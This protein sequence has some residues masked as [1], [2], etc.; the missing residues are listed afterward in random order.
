M[1]LPAKDMP[2]MRVKLL[3][4]SERIENERLI[5]EGMNGHLLRS[6]IYWLP[7]LLRLYIFIF[8]TLESAH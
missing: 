8:T 1:P 2:P 5:E 3:R 6:R 4:P 7:K